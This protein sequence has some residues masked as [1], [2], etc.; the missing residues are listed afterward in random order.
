MSSS[1]ISEVE[2]KVE[3]WRLRPEALK[4]KAE[5]ETY[6][7]LWAE[8][9]DLPNGDP[10]N[11]ARRFKKYNRVAWDMSAWEV[12]MDKHLIPDPSWAT[13]AHRE[14]L[15]RAMDLVDSKPLCHKGVVLTKDDPAA[16]LAKLRAACEAE[17][18]PIPPSL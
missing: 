1:K 11:R 6:M 10:V 13:E 9:K 3:A 8:V 15:R 5:C 12:F 2:G 16:D 14:Y 18:I 17:G 4:E 7:A